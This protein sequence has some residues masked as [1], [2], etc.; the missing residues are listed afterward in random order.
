M[1]ANNSVHSMF[2][3]RRAFDA[4]KHGSVAS[5]DW[6]EFQDQ[7]ID[8]FSARDIVNFPIGNVADTVAFGWQD[9]EVYEKYVYCA[10]NDTRLI[11]PV[12]VEVTEEI[13]EAEVVVSGDAGALGGF[14][15]LYEFSESAATTTINIAA[16]VANPWDTAGVAWANAVTY[17]EDSDSHASLPLVIDTTKKYFIYAKAPTNAAGSPVR[18]WWAHVR[19]ERYG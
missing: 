19:V 4:L 7:L 5:V 17:T 13:V 3:G 18:L 8:D 1:A 6:N 11:I 9:W 15:Y 14:L 10:T 2:R 12:N 16:G